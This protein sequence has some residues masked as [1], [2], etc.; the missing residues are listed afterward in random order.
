M[1]ASPPEPPTGSQP[2]TPAGEAA[3]PTT[4]A[5]AAIAQTPEQQL[6]GLR[7][8]VAQL[9]RK[10]GIRSYAGAAALVLAL[11]AG[12]VG[13][14]LA[15]SAKDDSATKDEVRALSKQLDSVSEEASATVEGDVAALRQRLDELQTRVDSLASAQRTSNSEL[16]VAQG[17]IEELRNQISDLRGSSGASAGATATPTTT[18]TTATA[19]TGGGQDNK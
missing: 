3:K 12:I 1:E 6:A 11:A 15:V 17:D 8:W 14:V 19:P 10:L 9:D 18:T 4:G 13:V 2:T 5:Q 16:E 7:A